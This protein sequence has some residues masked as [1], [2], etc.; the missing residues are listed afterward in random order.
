MTADEFPLFLFLPLAMEAGSM[1]WLVKFYN[2]N[3]GL[4]KAG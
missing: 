4:G 2:D 3:R 1:V